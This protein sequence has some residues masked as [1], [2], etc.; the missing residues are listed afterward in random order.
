M[1]GFSESMKRNIE[2]GM[3]GHGLVNEELREWERIT[4][5]MRTVLHINKI[6]CV[7]LF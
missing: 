7:W 3:K 4:Y 2:G 5:C 1:H 6:K